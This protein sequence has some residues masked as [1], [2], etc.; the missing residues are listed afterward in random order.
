ML[1]HV[2]PAPPGIHPRQMN[3]ALPPLRVEECGVQCLCRLQIW[4]A[5]KI[6]LAISF[7]NVRSM[8]SLLRISHEISA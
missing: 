5:L 3:R 4:L 6:K 2:I 8:V 1:P 7:L